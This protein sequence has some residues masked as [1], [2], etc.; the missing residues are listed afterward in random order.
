M[1]DRASEVPAPKPLNAIPE[2]RSDHVKEPMHK[3]FSLAWRSALSI[4]L[5]IVAPI[6]NSMRSESN[7]STTSLNEQPKSILQ[8]GQTNPREGLNAIVKQPP[9][10]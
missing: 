4:G 7:P 9:K 8:T 3:F 5:L 1:Q 10:K 2:R 6:I